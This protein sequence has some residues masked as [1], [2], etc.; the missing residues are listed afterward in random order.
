MYIQYIVISR[1]MSVIVSTTAFKT[2]KG[3][4]TDHVKNIFRD[5]PVEKIY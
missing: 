3:S 1:I 4:K 5:K 2:V